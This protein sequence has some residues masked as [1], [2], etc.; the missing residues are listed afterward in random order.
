MRNKIKLRK[1]ILSPARKKSNISKDY[2][3]N[4]KLRKIVYTT[5]SWEYW[6]SRTKD[7]WIKWTSQICWTLLGRLFSD[8]SRWKVKKKRLKKLIPKVKNSKWKNTRKFLR[9]WR[10]WKMPSRLGTICVYDT[11]IFLCSI[12]PK[13]KIYFILDS[14]LSLSL[15]CSAAMSGT[16]WCCSLFMD[17]NSTSDTVKN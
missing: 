3:K 7:N 13:Y 2:W 6:A 16:M 5:I 11:Y 12:I 9:K 1:E 17:S 10:K 4:Q 14:L 15:I 8:F